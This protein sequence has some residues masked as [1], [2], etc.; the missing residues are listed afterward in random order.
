MPS[1]GQLGWVFAGG[2]FDTIQG[3][4]G[5]DLIFGEDGLD[6]LSG[7]SENDRIFSGAGFHFVVGW[8][9]SRRNPRRGNADDLSDTNGDD[10]IHGGDGFDFIS[11]GLGADR[12]EGHAR[13]RRHARSK[14]GCGSSATVLSMST[15]RP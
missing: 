15:S 4:A 6:D 1:F 13:R 11:G 3:G 9:R 7:G 10:E 2:G 14:R 5:V 12:L 8:H